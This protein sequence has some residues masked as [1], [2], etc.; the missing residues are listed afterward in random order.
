M[1]TRLAVDDLIRRFA[2][3]SL[4]RAEWT[5]E[6]HL[7][8]GLWHVQTFG[9]SEALVRLRDGIRRLNESHGS[10]NTATT[11]YHETIT[12]AY[13]ELLAQFLARYAIDYPLE[14]VLCELLTSPLAARNALLTFYSHD[15]LFSTSARLSRA[16]P[17]LLPLD[18][19]HLDL[20]LR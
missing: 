8:V 19:K 9:P 4:P 6:A 11:G 14:Q 1:T 5:H 17:D 16:E 13:V 3:C 18:P 10:A 20:P 12:C 2:D 15:Y 7:T